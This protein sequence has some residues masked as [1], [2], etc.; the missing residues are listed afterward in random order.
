MLAGMIMPD[1]YLPDSDRPP[2]TCAEFVSRTWAG[3]THEPSAPGRGHGRPPA[4]LLPAARAG[5]GSA[6]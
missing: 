5:R 1:G 2:R 3:S 6:R 4:E